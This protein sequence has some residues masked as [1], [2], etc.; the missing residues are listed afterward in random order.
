MHQT[1]QTQRLGRLC[2]LRLAASVP[3]SSTLSLCCLAPAVTPVCEWTASTAG[4][5]GQREGRAIRFTLHLKTNPSPL[6]FSCRSV[7]NLVPVLSP[8]LL[9]ALF[10]HLG[11]N[12]YLFAEFSAF[13]GRNPLPYNDLFFQGLRTYSDLFIPI[14]L[15]SSTDRHRYRQRYSSPAALAPPLT[16]SSTAHTTD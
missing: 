3:N 4:Q 7:L 6:P 8:P 13:F 1:Q 5:P 14:V 11:L 10:L 2:P 9:P 12:A 16:K 15:K